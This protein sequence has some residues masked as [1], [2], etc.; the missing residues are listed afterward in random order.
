[1]ARKSMKVWITKENSRDAEVWYEKPMW[2]KVGRFFE[3]NSGE[4][5]LGSVCAMALKK[6]MNVEL[7][8]G[9]ILELKV[10]PIRLV[11]PK[12]HNDSIKRGE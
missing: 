9:Q 12:K 5:C 6:E 11:R 1:M 7:E 4:D 3:G 2:S 8:D 10:T